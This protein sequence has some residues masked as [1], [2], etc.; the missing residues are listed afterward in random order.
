M[1][2]NLFII[3]L[4]LFSFGF[5]TKPHGLSLL[6]MLD[7]DVIVPNFITIPSTSVAKFLDKHHAKALAQSV[8]VSEY[9]QAY[10]DNS[11]ANFLAM[12]KQ[13]YGSQFDFLAGTYNATDDSWSTSIATLYKQFK[14][15]DTNA[16]LTLAHPEGKR[17]GLWY[18]YAF[19]YLIVINSTGTFTGGL[20]Q[21]INYFAGDLLEC[22][23]W[24]WVHPNTSNW[25][26]PKFRDTWF[27]Y[28]TWPSR[29]QVN[30]FKHVDTNGQLEFVTS[31]GRWGIL[32][33]VIFRVDLNG[34]IAQ[35]NANHLNNT[36]SLRARV[37]FTI[38]CNA[39]FPNTCL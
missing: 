1:T 15:N 7:V 38:S 21:G 19:G 31:D 8:F 32:S 23:E 25:N 27:I 13:T 24:N 18:N 36:N 33:S 34:T 29:Q 16:V 26:N 17:T 9:T 4:A 22:L 37:Q 11:D 6:Y 14:G 5:A 35:N 2:N 30:S 39:G 10:M 20:R 28:P 3:F 12:L